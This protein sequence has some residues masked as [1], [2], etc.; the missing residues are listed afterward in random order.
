MTTYPF[1]QV[2]VFGARPLRGNPLAVVAA[3]D[4]L[5]AETMQ[6]IARWTDLSETTF[7]LAPEDPEA[8]YRSASSPRRASCPSPGIRHSA[9]RTSGEASGASRSE[10]G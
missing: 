5:D 9:R 4:D 8:D 2:D 10:R 7:L 3:A 1:C 6:A